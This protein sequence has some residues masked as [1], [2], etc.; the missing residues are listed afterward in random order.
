MA[1]FGMDGVLLVDTE[2]RQVAEQTMKAIRSF[3]EA[4]INVVVNT[5]APAF[6]ALYGHHARHHG[7]DEVIFA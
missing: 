1:L 2:N 5:P 6:G 4:A 7:A 3:T